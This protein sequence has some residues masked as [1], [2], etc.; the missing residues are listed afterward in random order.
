MAIQG[1]DAD[2]G[3]AS[4]FFQAHIQPDFREPCLGGVDQQLSISRTVGAGFTR[5]G[6]WLAFHV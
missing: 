4:D 1:A 5:R 6:R 3:A 2:S